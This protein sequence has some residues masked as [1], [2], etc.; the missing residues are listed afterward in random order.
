VKSLLIENSTD[1][2]T[3]AVAREGDV[4]LCREFSK[5]G[6][7]AAA[8]QEILLKAGAPDEIIV[9]IGP[10]SYTGLRVASAIAIGIQLALDCPAHGCP[11]VFGYKSDSYHV[12]GD[13]RLGAVFLASVE[14]RR[15]TRGPELLPADEFQSLRPKLGA[16]PIFAT[17]PIPG[18]SDLPIIRPEAQ[19]LIQ[20]RANFIPSLEPLYLKEPHISPMRKAL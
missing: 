8:V 17:G 13:A 4:L 11:S 5:A 14:D 15:L 3:V 20:C 12:V 7:L 10:G 19:Y 1:R 9:G 2:G 18:A 6:E 16:A